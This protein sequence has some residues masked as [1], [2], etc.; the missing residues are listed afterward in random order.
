MQKK[1]IARCVGSHR[2][3]KVRHTWSK[4]PGTVREARNCNFLGKGHSKEARDVCGLLGRWKS[5]SSQTC[6]SLR[7]RRVLGYG[8]CQFASRTSI[9]QT[10]DSGAVR[11]DKLNCEE[12]S[13]RAASAF[14]KIAVATTRCP[15]RC[16]GFAARYRPYGAHNIHDLD[17]MSVSQVEFQENYDEGRLL[18]REVWQVNGRVTTLG[19]TLVWRLDTIPIMMTIS[20]IPIARDTKIE[21]GN[22]NQR[23]VLG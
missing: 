3:A 7:A 5:R 4:I 18:A 17:N 23:R 8:T 16:L 2:H 1:S 14:T 20:P 6:H 10:C 15:A 9:L 21:L 11:R 12:A 13:C 22:C 19:K